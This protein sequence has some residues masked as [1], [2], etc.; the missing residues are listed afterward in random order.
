MRLV[1]GVLLVIQ[2]AERLLELGR[3]GY[4]GDA[5]HLPI[6]PPAWVPSATGYALLV[7][8]ALLGGGAAVVGIRGREGLLVASG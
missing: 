4:F 6:L 5:F 1:L 7:V 2:S 8:A 3:V